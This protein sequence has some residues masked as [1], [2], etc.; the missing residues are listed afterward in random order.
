MPHSEPRV[1]QG[2]PCT[3]GTRQRR[4]HVV[5]IR[6]LRMRPGEPIADL[7]L[8][9]ETGKRD[10]AVDMRPS[11]SKSRLQGEFISHLDEA[12]DLMRSVLLDQRS[13]PQRRRW[14]EI[15]KAYVGQ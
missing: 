12:H 8:G 3:L 5:E 2:K 4:D 9:I 1:E 10:D 7:V 14:S 15:A 11:L 13:E 6:T